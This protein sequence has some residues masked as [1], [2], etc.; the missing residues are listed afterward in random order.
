MSDVT[1]VIRTNAIVVSTE[2]WPLVHVTFRGHTDGAI[3]ERY[4]DDLTKAIRLHQGPRAIIMDASECGYVS[5]AM[6][7]RQA[8]WMRDNDAETRH[9]TAGIAFV[10][11]SPLLRGTLTAIL[12]VQP[13][14]CPYA[15]VK[16]AQAALKRCQAWLEPHGLSIPN[17]RPS[18]RPEPSEAKRAQGSSQT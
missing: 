18:Q 3:F 10:L 9:F 8:E 15:V 1:A 14:N 11:P 4:L 6:R 13:L 5:A 16:D 7:K 2:R 12:W 17:L